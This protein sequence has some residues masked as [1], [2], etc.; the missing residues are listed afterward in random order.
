MNIY[1]ELQD[2]KSKLVPQEAHSLDIQDLDP[3]LE[4][5]LMSTSKMAPDRPDTALVDSATTHSILRHSQYFQFED[6][7]RAWQTCELTT[8]ARKRNFKFHE[9]RAQLLLLG[10]T[11]LTL[12]KAMYALA[13]PHNFIS[14]KDLRAQGI[15]L[16]T[17]LVQGKEAIELKR[18]GETLAL[19]KVGTT[20]LYSVKISP[21]TSCAPSRQECAYAVTRSEPQR[22]L[23]GQDPAPG[24]WR[25]FVLVRLQRDL[26]PSTGLDLKRLSALTQANLGRKACVL[27]DAPSCRFGPHRE[28]VVATWGTNTRVVDVVFV[29]NTPN[30]SRLWHG[31]LGHPGATILRRMILL[32]EGHT[33]CVRDAE[34]TGRCSAC[35]QGKFTLRASH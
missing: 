30:K 33:L 11:P 14:Y 17:E 4:N 32:L 21:P 7:N 29:G 6:C 15:H 16:T 3:K 24:L 1:K 31:R 5:Y 20:G 25:D 12:A 2:L 34:H 8:I 19:A 27:S 18:R 35:A 10:G 23:G 22:A 26:V 9:G 13:A 28:P